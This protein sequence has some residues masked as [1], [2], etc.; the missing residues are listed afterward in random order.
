MDIYLCKGIWK[1]IAL[2]L[3]DIISICMQYNETV[4]NY[5]INTYVIF[6]SDFFSS[7]HQLQA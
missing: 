2:Q 4:Q 1:D 3:Y 6:K 7:Y 5:V